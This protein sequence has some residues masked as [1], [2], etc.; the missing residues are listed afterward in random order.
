LG[1][2]RWDKSGMEFDYSVQAIEI[3]RA[4]ID[5]SAFEVSVV[6]YTKRELSKP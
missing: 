3:K 6:G 1:I 2:I 4:M 5:P